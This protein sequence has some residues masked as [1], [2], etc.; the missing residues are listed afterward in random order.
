M[1]K[2]KLSATT[3]YFIVLCATVAAAI[4]VVI[5]LIL[6]QE[7]LPSRQIPARQESSDPARDLEKLSKRVDLHREQLSVRVDGRPFVSLEGIKKSAGEERATARLAR[8]WLPSFFYAKRTF[9]DDGI[10][11]L[12]LGLPSGTSG[13]AI[14]NLELM[15]SRAPDAA[16]AGLQFVGSGELSLD[17]SGMKVEAGWGPPGEG[18]CAAELIRTSRSGLLFLKYSCPSAIPMR[19]GFLAPGYSLSVQSLTITSNS[20]VELGGITVTDAQDETVLEIGKFSLVTKGEFPADMLAEGIAYEELN[21]LDGWEA[22]LERVKG[23]LSALSKLPLFRPLG[24]LPS[25]ELTA[26]RIEAGA[27]GALRFLN[28]NLRKKGQWKLQ[29]ILAAFSPTGKGRLFSLDKPTFTDDEFGLEIT[30]PAA[31]VELD[32]YN[33]YHV[34]LDG[35]TVRVAP[36]PLAAAGLLQKGAAIRAQIARIKAGNLEPVSLGLPEGFPD[37]R[38]EAVNGDFSFPMVLDVPVTGLTVRATATGGQLEEGQVRLCSGKRA[39]TDL[40]ASVAVGTDAVG[41]VSHL[42]VDLAG[43]VV[44]RQLTKRFKGVFKNLDRAGVNCSLDI[45][46]GQKQLKATCK[47]SLYGLTVEH[48]KLALVPIHFPLL[49]VEAD[50]AADLDERKLDISMPKLQMGEVYARAALD[51]SEFLTVPAFRLTVDFPEQ[52][53]SA[54]LRSVPHGFTPHLSDARVEGVL[55]FGLNFE[56]DLRDVRRSI[57][58][59]IDGD[60]DKCRALTLGPDINVEEL[61]YPDYVHRVVVAGEDLGVDVG[62]GTDYYIPLLQVPQA[63]QAAAYGTE[64]LAFFRHRGFRTGLIRRALILL[65]ERGYFAYGGSTISQQLVKNLFLNRRKTLS[66]KFEEAIIVWHMEKV[67]PKKRIFELYLNCIEYGPKIW[68][69]ARASRTYFAKHPTQLTTMEGAFLMGLKPDPAYG[70]LQYRRG[71]LNKHWRKNLDRVL[72]RLLDMGAISREY[73]DTAMRTRLRFK[74]RKEKGAAEGAAE[75][76]RP[77][78]EGQ[79]AF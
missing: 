75:E 36:G 18:Q 26:D 62:P 48:K 35:Y 47:A 72:K 61:N 69:I 38:L 29:A 24:T 73:Y 64:D 41:R 57:K 51:I 76:D 7:S 77:V 10:A 37:M 3:L 44:A 6:N 78:R 2:K 71:G 11:H 32:Q 21:R 45:P 53:C 13:V 1:E 17:E 16:Y 60:L 59:S 25:A 55:W 5:Y 20:Y 70:Y 79:E 33:T 15:L 9:L 43:T 42:D 34:R 67:V 30:A 8:V 23:D 12:F 65:F 63:V 66:R 28:M 14:E 54:L 49:R 22:S 50:V 19:A 40:E 56:V 39:C 58:L 52:S 4:P 74:G 31:A 46:S 27:S 68:G